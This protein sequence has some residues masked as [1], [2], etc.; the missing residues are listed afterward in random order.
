MTRLLFT[1]LAALAAGI[2]ACTPEPRA[3][4]YFEAHPEAL[5]QALNACQA[6]SLRGRECDNA[7]LAETHR[8]AD[9]RMRAFRQGFD[10]EPPPP[11]KPQAR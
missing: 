7:D 1:A 3:A 4:A 5:R 9:A 10:P 11:A 2:C 6:G 8:A